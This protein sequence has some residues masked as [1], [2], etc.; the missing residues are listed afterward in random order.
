MI[1][2]AKRI[3]NG[4]VIPLIDELKKYHNEKIFIKIEVIEQSQEKEKTIN[5]SQ[6]E[7]SGHENTYLSNNENTNKFRPSGLCKG[8]FEVPSDF[9]EQLPDYILNEYEGGIA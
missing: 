2:E 9:D 6:P 3:D 1:V 8:D 7:L 4:Y 5:I